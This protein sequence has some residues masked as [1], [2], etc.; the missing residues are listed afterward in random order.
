MVNG[1]W[2]MAQKQ[3]LMADG[4]WLMAG[5]GGKANGGVLSDE[6]RRGA[7]APSPECWVL[8]LR[9]AQGHPEQRRGVSVEWRMADA[10]RSPE[11]WVLSTGEPTPRWSRRGLACPAR[12]TRARPSAGGAP[13][14]VP[15][16]GTAVR[17]ACAGG[18][19]SP[20]IVLRPW[21]SG[22]PLGPFIVQPM[23]GEHVFQGAHGV[24]GMKGL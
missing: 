10:N 20:P 13:R 14:P 8:T 18:L 16:P 12:A 19:L 17:P 15:W 22:F 11:C 9:R 5:G 4:V 7:A 3:E 6:W 21:G 23:P 1:R 24:W 2:L